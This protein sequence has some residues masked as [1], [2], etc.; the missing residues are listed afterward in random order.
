[1]VNVNSTIL[2]AAGEH[3]V[4]AEL[5]RRGFIA[6]KAPEG[7]PNFDIVITD[8]LGQRLAAIQVKTRRDYPGG[9]KGWHMKSKHEELSSDHM[10][11]VFVDVGA[12]EDAPVS[13][14]VLPSS[15]VATVCRI[16]HEI[17]RLTPNS[18][19]GEHGDSPLR[20]ML[21]KY[22]LPKYAQKMGYRPPKKHAEFFES[23]AAGWMEKYRN[24]WHLIHQ[25]SQ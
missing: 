24:A 3:Y 6:A 25:A 11:Y 18:N 13:F 20:R 16:S 10:F 21:P 1:M 12:S 14:Y 23:Y 17:W 9:D 22:E 7:V 19:G 15:L 4:L 5:L 8:L 2:G